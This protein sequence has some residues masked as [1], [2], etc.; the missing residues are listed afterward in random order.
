M[1]QALPAPADRYHSLFLPLWAC[2]VL[3]Q[4]GLLIHDVSAAWLISG[5]TRTNSI[6][7]LAQ[8]ASTLPFFLL[9]LPAG[10]LADLISRGRIIRMV[11]FALSA[12]SL[13]T[14][15]AA[16][17]GMASIP[18][19]LAASFLNG[20]G[21]ALFTPAWQAL[22]PE[23]VTTQRL[24]GALALN[25]LGMNIARSI[26]PVVAGLVLYAS[27]PAAAFLFNAALYALVGL[28]FLARTPPTAPRSRERLGA[29]MAG[30]IAYMRND[31]QLQ[32][33]AAKAMAFFFFA[34]TFWALAPVIVHDFFAG[35]GLMLGL[36]VGAVG[37]GA[38]LAALLLKR[39]RARFDIDRL[40]LLAGLGGALALALVP[41][42]PN[43]ALAAGIYG[44]LGFCWL[45]AFS[46]I[47]LAAQFRLTPWI[48]ARGTSF[49]LIAVFGSVAVG[50]ALSGVVSDAVGP[51]SAYLASAAGLC[52]A[53]LAVARL[54]ITRA[55]PLA[56]SPSRILRPCPTPASPLALTI[57]YRPHPTAWTEAAQSLA[58]LRQVRLRTGA[59]T[60]S[61]VRT[62][63]DLQERITFADAAALARAAERQSA[64]DAALEAR[65]LDL[66]VAPPVLEVQAAGDAQS[67]GI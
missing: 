7:A 53:T 46:S 33:I 48:R 50:S 1:S 28:V 64:E 5:Q 57:R 24:P 6:V 11:A 22:T 62:T 47:H 29:A 54:K 67:A 9:A 60:W 3:L 44:A 26:G 17:A 25:S 23:I 59:Q 2:M 4:S 27:G 8:T 66:L 45:I 30:G 18:L 49:Y 39:L 40:M 58:A 51:T 42:A 36:L 20:C 14:A 15:A 13:A 55:A 65:L 35:T 12:L 31:P 63:G 56:L 41:A 10:A 52:L 21:N 43:L 61:S 19:L 16:A 37:V 38:V 34:S 32:R